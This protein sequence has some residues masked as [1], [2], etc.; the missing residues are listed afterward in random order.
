MF[1]V[2]V[3]GVG[4]DA[5]DICQDVA[6]KN[7]AIDSFPEDVVCS[8]ILETLKRLLTAMESDFLDQSFGSDLGHAFV[9]QSYIGDALEVQSS[10]DFEEYLVRS[11]LH[12]AVV[13]SAGCGGQEF[14]VGW[15]KGGEVVFLST[16]LQR[17]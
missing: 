12:G 17:L 2:V 16:E 13:I 8:K 9:N 1:Q 15:R 6:L 14:A 11:F 4:M 10:E 5:A 3:S 7:D